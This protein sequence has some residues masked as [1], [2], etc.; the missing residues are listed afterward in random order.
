MRM[1]AACLFAGVAITMTAGSIPAA[2]KVSPVLNHKVKS[3]KGEE[4]DLS[5]YQGKVLLVVNVASRC[6]ATP[7]YEQLESLNAKYKDKGLAV[8]GFPCNQF[9]SQEPGTEE[10]IVKFCQSKYNVSFDMFAK[11]DVNGADASPVYKTLTQK[12]T[13]PKFAGDIKWNFEKFLI[14][15]DGSIVARFGTGVKPDAP[16]VVKAIEAELAKSAK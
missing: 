14:G 2:E 1:F 5:K 9:G 4:V 13:D 11:I 8:L 6:G 15:R 3:I 12:E 16:D 7:Q 10:D